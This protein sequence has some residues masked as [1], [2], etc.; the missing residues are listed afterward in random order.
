M[1]R[2]YFLHI[3]LPLFVLCLA[4]GLYAAGASRCRF[5]GSQSYGSGCPYN[6]NGRYHVH[7]GDEQSCV[8]CG[9]SSYGSGC[10]YSPSRK[11]IHGHGAK[12]IY[13]GSTSYGSGCPYSPHRYHER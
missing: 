11:H 10:P 4:A 1:I 7:I 6:V 3:A 13:C 2:K 12:C 5:C 8:Y 9:S